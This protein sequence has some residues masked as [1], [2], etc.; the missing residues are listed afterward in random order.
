MTGKYEEYLY[1]LFHKYDN[2]YVELD[3]SFVLGILSSLGCYRKMYIYEEGFGSYRR[4]RWG[5]AKGLKK[6]IN[7][8]TGVGEQVGFSRFL[9]GQYLYLPDL[10]TELF[11]GYG[12]PVYLFRKSFLKH[13]H[14]EQELFLKLSEGYE[15]FTAIR[16]RKVAIY[17]TTHEAN[18]TILK[19]ILQQKSMFDVLFVKPHPH[20]CDLSFFEQYSMN[21]IRSNIMVE[22]ILSCLIENENEL[23]VYHENSTAVLWFQNKIV[24]RNMGK[25]YEEY[26]M[27]ASYVKEHVSER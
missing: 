22:Y 27:V 18:T 7:N 16:N 13:L 14:D 17:L 1:L 5:E 24:N 25:P 9:T 21:L 3:A 2:L 26:D 10:Y 15:M 8:R 19:E 6:W 20:L 23:T 12:K 4:D 11:P